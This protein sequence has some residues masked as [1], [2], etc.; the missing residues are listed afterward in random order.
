MASALAEGRVEVRVSGSRGRHLVAT[1]RLRAGDIVLVAEPYAAVLDD[2]ARHLR[3]DHTFATAADAGV[4]SLLRCARSKVARYASREA[5]AAAWREGYKEECAALVACAPGVPPPT[6]RLA[7]RVL[8]RRRR[9]RARPE[10]AY[11]PTA[12]AGNAGFGEG[13][14][15]VRALVHHWDAV[16]EEDKARFAHAGAAA[17]AFL[18]ARLAGT[19]AHPADAPIPPA[20]AD[21]PVTEPEPTDRDPEEIP[22]AVAKLVAR[23]SFNCHALCDDESRPY[24]VGVFPTAAAMNHACAPNCAQSFRGKTLTVRCLRDVHPEEEL[25]IAYVELAVTRAERRAELMKQYAFDIDDEDGAAEKASKTFSTRVLNANATAASVGS[26]ATLHDH[27]AFP[28]SAPPWRMDERDVTHACVA[29]VRGARAGGVVV[30]GPARDVLQTSAGIDDGAF[31]EKR[32]DVHV[33]GPLAADGV[34]AN[35]EH[36]AAVAAELARV[37]ADAERL[38]DE[39]VALLVENGGG[40]RNLCA[41]RLARFRRLVDGSDETHGF[42]LGEGHALRHRAHAVALRIQIRAGDFPAARKTARAFLLPAYRRAYPFGHPPLAAHLALL[43]KIE[44]FLGGAFLPAAARHGAEA[45]AMLRVC[46]GRSPMCLAVER[47]LR[48]T[49]HEL[50][51][52]GAA[53]SSGEEEEEDASFAR[54]ESS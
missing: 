13:Y 1:Q 52:S 38:A 8:W 27:G 23:L 36:V 47:S 9:E 40:K 5:Q 2:A 44:T 54:E 51:V 20:K 11:V 37:V 42:A 7:A 30:V 43:A 10:T 45:L 15:S 48:E 33:W 32:V 46:Q 4:G 3:C 39:E 53:S 19:N 35:R 26:S 16:A 31:L 6:V 50:A 18:D 17:V 28:D 14:D 29:T 12:S 25:T 24:G 41:E 21:A 22:L 34:V 49:E